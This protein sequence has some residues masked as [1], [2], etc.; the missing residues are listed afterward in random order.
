MTTDET[1]MIDLN[2]LFDS[3][4]YD[5]LLDYCEEASRCSD[6]WCQKFCSREYYIRSQYE[7]SRVW[8]E[9]LAQGGDPE[10]WF[11]LALNCLAERKYEQA[12]PYLR[13]AADKGY[14]R[15]NQWIGNLY[16]WG[17]GVPK[18]ETLAL[19][20]YRKGAKYGFIAAQH[21]VIRL[22]ARTTLGRILLYPRLVMLAVKAVFIYLIGMLKREDDVRLIDISAI[23]S[24]D[25]D[26]FKIDANAKARKKKG[27]G[28][29]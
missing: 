4:R 1:V 15:A 20:W 14:G 23:Q 16:D 3:K 27:R 10:G 19:E 24:E 12:L 29:P 18:D 25:V 17:L 22:E 21:S 28:V 7:K 26:Y 6:P 11:G 13:E 8:F 5:E 2:S 9:R